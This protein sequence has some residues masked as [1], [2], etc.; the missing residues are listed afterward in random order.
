[1]KKCVDSGLWVG[2][3]V[4]VNKQ[5]TGVTMKNQ[6]SSKKLIFKKET[7]VELNRLELDIVRGGTVGPFY[8]IAFSVAYANA[9]CRRCD[10]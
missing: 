8:P 2:Y 5:I 3:N 1:M 7:I 10:L 4:D 6:T 9:S